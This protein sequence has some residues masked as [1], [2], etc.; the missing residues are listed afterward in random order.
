MLC[1]VTA[2]VEGRA[3]SVSG[4]CPHAPA[5]YG[6]GTV[7]DAVLVH[8]EPATM[9]KAIGAATE[10][11]VS[12][13]VVRVHVLPGLSIEALRPVVSMADALRG[14]VIP[15]TS[16]DSERAILAG[17]RRGRAAA[18]LGELANRA[19][20]VLL[21]GVGPEYLSCVR[22][23]I[24]DRPGTHV[25]DGRRGRT[26][27]A[28]RIGTAGVLDGAD[29]S[30]TLDPSDE[31]AALSLLQ[32]AAR[33]QR[34]AVPPRLAFVDAIASR[35]SSAR[36][37]GIVT[38]TEAPWAGSDLEPPQEGTRS[39]ER[40]ESLI[41]LAQ[42]WNGPTRAALLSL[43][44]GGNQ[45]GAEAL[46]TWQA[47]YPL[48][49]SYSDGAPASGL[50]SVAGMPAH[51]AVL[52]VGYGPWPAGG[53]GNS[54]DPARTVSIGPRAS[55]QPA[56]AQGVVIDTGVLGVHEAGTAYRCDDV[57]LSVPSVAEGMRTAAST[58]EALE[59]SVARAL[60]GAAL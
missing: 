12:G 33:G 23:R 31:L 22:R 14:L 36:Y 27:V 3:V 18:T 9:E 50:G 11:L 44:A 19:D 5:W 55:E 49:V 58:L 1:E 54:P 7:P 24:I 38:P 53:R 32:C 6:D 40:S 8:G 34:V 17:Q 35:M 30:G 16:A 56:A 41:A 10:I 39:P 4:D 28:I 48:R 26:V 52:S 42:A 37:I 20:V 46:L 43:R 57:P 13:P 25:P 21:W 45:N 59:Q 2:H 47:G 60:R 15:P 29:L 51:A